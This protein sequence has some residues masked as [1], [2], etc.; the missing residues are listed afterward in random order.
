MAILL[1]KFRNKSKIE[2]IKAFLVND[3]IISKKACSMSE[4]TVENSL[5]KQ[6]SERFG[7][8]YVTE[9]CSVGEHF[10]MKCD[11]DMFQGLCGIELKLA[12]SLENKAE[13]FHR[14]IGQIACYAHEEYTQTCVIL[15][16]VGQEPEMSDKIKELK[17]IVGQLRRVEFIYKQAANKKQLIKNH[18]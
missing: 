4:K 2:E 15:L 6:L 11:V 14:A 5:V 3:L 7:E 18:V 16:I 12:E 8:K 1:D 9:Q 17:A 13:E 10:N